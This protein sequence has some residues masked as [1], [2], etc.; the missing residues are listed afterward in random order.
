[1]FCQNRSVRGDSKHKAAFTFSIIDLFVTNY[2]IRIL[3][4]GGRVL[5]S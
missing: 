2:L 5:Y 4:R 3:E 1:M